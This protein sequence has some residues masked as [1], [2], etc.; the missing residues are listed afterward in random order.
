MTR[1]TPAARA[2]NA[3]RD[4]LIG[5]AYRMLGDYGEA[6]DVAS[7]IAIAALE[8][9]ASA[10]PIRSWP[11]W[12]TTVAVRRSI[13]RVRHLAAR[14]ETYPGPWLPEPVATDRLP[15][16][17]VATRELL[18]VGLLHLAEQ[19]DPDARAAV[20]LHRAYGMTAPEI[21]E[22]LERSPASVRQLV[23]RAERKLDIDA[24]AHL[25]RADPIA[26]AALVEA[27]ERGDVERVVSF[28][29]EDAVLLTDGGG[30]VSAARNPVTGAH[31][32]AR[33]LIGVAEK[34]RRLGGRIEY[35]PTEV[36]GER[37]FDARQ[38]G[39][40]DVAVATLGPDGRIRAIRQVCN[41]E[42]LTRV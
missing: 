17:V 15:D 12:L 38:P 16:D 29:D 10:A 35:R 40:R 30:R 39:R 6:E 31:A 34:A 24:D 3:E 42:K 18:S 11:A 7:E 21:G 27:I 8:A 32:V 41:P 25:P 23:S 9:E 36:N 13:D 33:F 28:L 19:L 1:D 2:W 26:L 37:G 4:R 5:I 14:R 20:V 22:I